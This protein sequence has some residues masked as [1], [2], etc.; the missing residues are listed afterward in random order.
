MADVGYIRVSTIDQ[1]T[2]RQLDG[3]SLDKIFVDKVSGV[4]CSRPALKECLNYLREGDVLHVHSIDRLA[5]NLAD[6]QKLVNCLTDRGIVVQFHTENLTFSGPSSPMQTLLFQIMGAFAQ[7]ERALIKERQREG[8]ELAKANG[9]HLGRPTKLTESDR[10]TILDKLR[11]G[12]A[13]PALLAKEYGVSRSTI[14]KLYAKARQEQ[15]S[16]TT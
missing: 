8:F 3:I 14:H 16:N 11:Q 4:V 12:V 10:L 1:S 9:K 15:E 7:F 5:R 2:A 13:D 6:L